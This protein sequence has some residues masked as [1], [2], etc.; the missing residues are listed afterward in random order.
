MDEAVKALGDALAGIASTVSRQMLSR[1]AR[2]DAVLGELQGVRIGIRSSIPPVT[3]HL[4]V[5]DA[6]LTFA[7]GQAEQCNATIT[8]E[9][10]QLLRWLLSE[11]DSAVTI[12]GDADSAVRIRSALRTLAAETTEDLAQTVSGAAQLGL[13]TLRSGIE[14]LSRAMDTPPKRDS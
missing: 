11:D 5:E 4:T 10:P 12:E 1:S 7:Q 13:E 3:W 8:G 14:Q 2:A 6:A 9:P